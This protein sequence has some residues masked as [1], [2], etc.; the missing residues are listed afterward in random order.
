MPQPYRKEFREDV[1]R[2]A[3][4]REPGVPLEQV[5]A[6]FGAPRASSTRWL[7]RTDIDEGARPG[8]TSS[9]SAGLREARGRVRMREQESEVL[10][11]AAACLPQAN[12]PAK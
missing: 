12:L 2:V 10:R 4:N 11:R 7:R 3:C 5:A 6:D 9:E 8:T 1:V